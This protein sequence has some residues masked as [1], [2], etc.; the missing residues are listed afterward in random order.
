LTYPPLL[1]GRTGR[2][3]HR[4]LASSLFTDEDEPIASFLA[5]TLLETGQEIPDFL[6]HHVSEGQELKF[7]AD[8]DSEPGDNADGDWGTGGDIQGTNEAQD[9]NDGGWGN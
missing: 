1:T 9:A 5:R 8:S 7:E 6:Q 3:G 2:I 4:G